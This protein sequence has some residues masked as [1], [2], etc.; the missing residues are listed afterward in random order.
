MNQFKKY[1]VLLEGIFTCFTRILVKDNKK[2]FFSKILENDFQIS[3][4]IPL[5]LLKSVLTSTVT[6]FYKNLFW[7]LFAHFKL[8]TL[9]REWRKW[10]QIIIKNILYYKTLISYYC[11]YYNR[12]LKEMN[13]IAEYSSSMVWHIWG[14][15]RKSIGY[16]SAFNIKTVV[17][18]S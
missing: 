9:N 17:A 4:G 3:K 15:N 7:K 2:I 16:Q 13:N 10:M 1:I 18:F 14:H 8:F 12:L 5:F 11:S 6:H